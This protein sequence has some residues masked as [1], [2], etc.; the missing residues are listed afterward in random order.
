MLCQN[1][2]KQYS[3]ASNEK[4]KGKPQKSGIKD[5][6]EDKSVK[7]NFSGIPDRDLVDSLK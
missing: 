2:N 1:I 3:R 6:L 7:R 4:A 5:K